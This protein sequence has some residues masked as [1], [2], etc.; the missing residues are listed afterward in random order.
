MRVSLDE[1]IVRL[2][3]GPALG[4]TK[5]SRIWFDTDSEAR[6]AYFQRLDVLMK[7][8]FLDADRSLG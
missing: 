8:G 6:D 7:D 3:W 4:Q 1:K 2:E 5:H